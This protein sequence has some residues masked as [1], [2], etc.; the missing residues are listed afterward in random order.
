MAT[1]NRTR[2]DDLALVIEWGNAGE[3]GNL[4]EDGVESV[5]LFPGLGW[6]FSCGGSSLGAGSASGGVGSALVHE[7]IADE[8]TDD[9]KVLSGTVVVA[10]YAPGR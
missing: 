1:Q 4:P 5:S 8:L 10:R 7:L 6:G 3:I 2:G 9:V